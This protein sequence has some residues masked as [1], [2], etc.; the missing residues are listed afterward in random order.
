[1]LVLSD[2]YLEKKVTTGFS[3]NFIDLSV[4]CTGVKQLQSYGMSRDSWVYNYHIVCQSLTENSPEPLLHLHV[5][6]S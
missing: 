1:M 6:L 3:C 2:V 5:L 4:C